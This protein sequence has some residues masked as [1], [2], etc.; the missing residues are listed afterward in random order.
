M[1]STT[2][3]SWQE[4]ATSLEGHMPMLA[5]TCNAVPSAVMISGNNFLD[6]T[7]L[8]TLAEEQTH[9]KALLNIV[10]QGELIV[11]RI[12]A[13]RSVSRC[14]PVPASQ[15]DADVIKASGL[16]GI[17]GPQL[18]P[19]LRDIVRYG[20]T[21]TQAITAA[22]VYMASS[23]R[24]GLL[25]S[26]NLHRII[27][28]ALDSLLNVGLLLSVKQAVME[29]W[30]RY[31]TAAMAELQMEEM[32][33][34]QNV[35]SID[36][37]RNNITAELRKLGGIAEAAQELLDL[38][39]SSLSEDAF[40]I[41][42]EKYAFVHVTAFVVGCI[43][44]PKI[45]SKKDLVTIVL[46]MYPLVPIFQEI[47]CVLDA[48]YNVTS[49]LPVETVDA[50][51]EKYLISS[52]IDNF[53]E[54]HTTVLANLARAVHI[55]QENPMEDCEFVVNAVS[56][57]VTVLSQ[58]SQALSEHMSFKYANPN[59][60]DAEDISDF[61]RYVARNHMPYEFQDLLEAVAMVKSLS[62]ALLQ[63]SA[64]AQGCIDKVI[65]NSTQTFIQTTMRDYLRKAASE[66]KT[67]SFSLLSQLRESLGD[68]NRA[69]GKTAPADHCMKGIKDTPKQP[70]PTSF[71][72][73]NRICPPT[74]TQLWFFESVLSV[75]IRARS[76][77]KK[78]DFK[79]ERIDAM[80]SM[81]R[82][83][84]Q[85]RYLI[86]LSETI[87]LVSD[88]SFLWAREWSLEMCK[89][90]IF[91]MTDSLLYVAVMSIL[92]S[93][94][95]GDVLPLLDG[96]SAALC[97]YND[98]A[99]SVLKVWRGQAQF[100]ELQCEVRVMVES[101]VV[102]LAHLLY[103]HAKNASAVV[104]LP[105]DFVTAYR[106]TQ[107]SRKA[108]KKAKRKGKTLG[109]NEPQG[110]NL[111]VDHAAHIE[112][113]L[114][115]LQ[116]P[117]FTVLGQRISLQEAVSEQIHSLL[118]TDVYNLLA[119]KATANPVRF[120]TETSFMHEVLRNTVELLNREDVGLHIDSWENIW[121]FEC[122]AEAPFEE[123]AW[124]LLRTV[125][126]D[127]Y[128]YS[129]GTQR[130]VAREAPPPELM[131]EVNSFFTSTEVRRAVR[132]Y[133]K[134]RSEFIGQEHIDFLLAVMGKEY[135]TLRIASIIKAEVREASQL[136]VQAVRA[137]NS[138]QAP[139]PV[140]VDLHHTVGN[141]LCL[142]SMFGRAVMGYALEV[143]DV[144]SQ[145]TRDE[146][147]PL[148]SSMMSLWEAGGEGI[149]WCV[150]AMLKILD[151]YSL[152]RSFLSTQPRSVPIDRFH[153]IVESVVTSTAVVSSSVA[154]VRRSANLSE[155]LSQGTVPSQIPADSF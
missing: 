119:S 67:V 14:L 70:A 17:V 32:L 89:T 121:R 125:V 94:C 130:F 80:R 19:L 49:L 72:A 124:S 24:S 108:D 116:A 29:D 107:V 143:A 114:S 127:Q 55:K 36:S 109:L 35:L 11:P 92:E 135:G 113:L 42:K 10:Q 21:A 34:I 110:L 23:A 134:K 69:P 75:V 103:N 66:K 139:V 100:R 26:D 44:R 144:S 149:P 20:T 152:Y 9:A 38:C 141:L 33:A 115:V 62:H 60:S 43:L 22:V 37:I 79:E 3:L 98:A 83:V 155:L 74:T 123:H 47:T 52:V 63:L 25:T 54:E 90:N 97:V 65:Y 132:A 28:F 145:L 131:E 87:F 31:K 71:A 57:A 64:Q 129:T 82:Q 6:V 137:V 51:A 122:N 111:A 2:T 106:Q 45:T 13:Y 8:T 84:R 56:S 86:H 88:T 77:G 16:R 76:D 85:W 142:A 148:V 30:A 136:L 18:V 4:G 61:A 95:G 120:I 53:R 73:S 104:T 126:V 117:Y 48:C 39:T 5:S 101:V 102:G 96:F 81:L 46:R 91:P 59:T 112:R 7:S 146:Y 41:P 12:Y 58:L 154:T 78:L 99:T 140:A 147:V 128:I 138:G 93:Q 50:G 151:G 68:W 27:V 133:Y 1:S 150:A 15:A 153:S 118:I 105:P 40:L